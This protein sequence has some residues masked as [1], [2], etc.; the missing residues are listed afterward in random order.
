MGIMKRVATLGAIAAV[1]VLAAKRASV[2]KAL[3]GLLGSGTG[4]VH[5]VADRA[6][7]PASRADEA[8][9][10]APAKARRKTRATKRV[11]RKGAKKPRA[12]ARP[13]RAGA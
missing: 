10:P 8:S 1:G 4:V 2:K 5:S 13:P 9:S 6:E 7:Q 12:G 11:A 3:R